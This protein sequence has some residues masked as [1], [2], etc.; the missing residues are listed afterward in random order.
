MNNG[1]T[2]R[3]RTCRT[4]GTRR[5]GRERGHLFQINGRQWSWVSKRAAKPLPFSGWSASGAENNS[6]TRN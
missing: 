6:H 5:E 1:S 2:E 4:K 3:A